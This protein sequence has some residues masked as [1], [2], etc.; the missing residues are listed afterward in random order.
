MVRRRIRLLH[1]ITELVIGGAQDNTLLTVEGLDPAVYEIDV[2]A[3]PGGGWVERARRAAARVHL[4]THMRREI[5][6]RHDLPALGEVYRLLRREHYDIVHT[7]SSKAGLIGRVAARLAGVP[8]VVHTVHGFP[9]NDLTYPRWLRAAYVWLERLGARCC[10]CLVMVA[11]LNKEEALRRRIAPAEMMHVVYSGIDLRRFARLPHQ[12]ETR[13]RLGLAPAGRVVG[14]V[15]RL[16]ACNAPLTFVAAAR[17]LLERYPDLE[18]VIAGDGELRPQVEQAI[19]NDPRIRLLGFRSDIPDI[20]AALDVF[21]FPNLW[22]G[23]GRS[24]TEALAAGIPVVA[25]PVNGVPELVIDGVTGLHARVGDAADLAAK[26]A[27]LLDQ[28]E[29]ATRLAAA[30]RRRVFEHFS[31]ERMVADLDALYRQLLAAKAPDLVAAGPL[32]HPQAPMA[33][34][35]R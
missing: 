25:F 26:A 17:A 12:R 32:P 14:T 11:E 23:L 13:E 18:V 35:D 24:V 1:L 21:L 22:G 34:I 16:S 20:L 8:V 4:L 31:A 6:P 33:S 29:L 10:D 27:L 3:A 30:G 7:H 28:P 19:A 5:A 15:G 9:F 2:A